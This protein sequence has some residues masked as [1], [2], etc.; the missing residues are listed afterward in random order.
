LAVKAA[1]V[2]GSSEPRVIIDDGTAY[3]IGPR[4][5]VVGRQSDVNIVIA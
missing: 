4:P 5:L 3:A 1:F 2:G